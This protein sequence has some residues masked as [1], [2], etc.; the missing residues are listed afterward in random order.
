MTEAQNELGRVSSLKAEAL[1]QPGSRRFRLLVEARA[2]GSAMLW[3]EKQQLF[4]L[5]VAIK[6]IIATVEQQRRTRPRSTAPPARLGD[7]SSVGRTSVELQVGR[8][9]IGY[10]DGAALYII[11]GYAMES[12]EDAVPVVSLVA[13]AEQI[14]SL[15]DEAF[16]V[17]AAGRPPCPLCGAPVGPEPH[18]CPRHNG[19]RMPEA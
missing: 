19:H 6:R 4:N 11:A 7:T 9:A 15:A 12:E 3:L 5:G 14:D 16:A 2:G 1:G 13:A 10:D 18:V 8:M 17:C